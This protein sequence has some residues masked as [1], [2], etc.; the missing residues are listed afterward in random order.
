M[1][2]MS[3]YNFFLDCPAVFRKITDF[4][5]MFFCLKFSFKLYFVMKISCKVNLFHV[6]YNY[7]KLSTWK[8]F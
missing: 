2:H 7:N 6:P 5:M 1:F 8:Y 4:K 3:F